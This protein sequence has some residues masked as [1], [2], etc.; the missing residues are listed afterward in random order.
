MHKKGAYEGLTL[1][2]I[3]L[4]NQKQNKYN[5][6]FVP[7][8]SSRRYHDLKAGRYQIIPFESKSW[9]WPAESI[10]SSKVFLRGTEVFIANREK[11]KSQSYFRSLKGKTIKGMQ[12]YHYGFLGLSTSHQARKD[13]NVELTNTLDGN[14]RSI[15]TKRADVA[16]VAKEYLSLY[17][18]KHPDDRNKLLISDKYDQLYDLGIIVS[19]RS[20]PISSDE[21]NRLIDVITSDGSWAEVLKKKNIE[22]QK[23][24]N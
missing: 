15:V 4:L 10:D 19:K 7:T 12:G 9:G 8:S 17:L 20:S 18:S 16:I 6:T 11:A 5:F 24:Q 21:L 2:L 22:P 1:D 13:F 3:A 14:I 23:L